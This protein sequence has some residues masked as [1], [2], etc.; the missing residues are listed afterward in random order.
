MINYEENIIPLNRYLIGFIFIN[1]AYSLGKPSLLKQLVKT[2]GIKHYTNYTL[3]I[4]LT[5]YFGYIIGSVWGVS[6]II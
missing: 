6:S 3:L 5:E 2:L 1:L 4:S